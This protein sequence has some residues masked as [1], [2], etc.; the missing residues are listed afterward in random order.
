MGYFDSEEVVAKFAYFKVSES[1]KPAAHIQIYSF[2]HFASNISSI[3]ET[4]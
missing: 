1:H 2:F 3:D 4:R